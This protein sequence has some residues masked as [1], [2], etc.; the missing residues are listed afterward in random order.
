[1]TAVSVNGML[2]FMKSRNLT[3]YPSFLSIPTPAMLA[4]A[5][6]GVRLPPKVAHTRSP[7]NRKY[8]SMFIAFA[9]L[10]RIGS[11]VAV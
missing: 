7:K 5:P 11:I 3:S 10:A 8:G 6:M 9:T 2:I 4:D 1:M